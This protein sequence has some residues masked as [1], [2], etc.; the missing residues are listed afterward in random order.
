MNSLLIT[1][2][3]LMAVKF[4]FDIG[5]AGLFI[6]LLRYFSKE[7]DSKSIQK[8]LNAQSKKRLKKESMITSIFAIFYIIRVL[9]MDLGYQII[10]LIHF[11]DQDSNNPILDNIADFEK[12]FIRFSL[13]TV[14]FLICMVLLTLFK[15]YAIKS[16]ANEEKLKGYYMMNKQQISDQIAKS[17]NTH[18]T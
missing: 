18:S 7:R 14:D 1:F 12:K 3:I 9:I 16:M 17:M 5:M 4:L 2:R 15:M 13:Y 8:K 6:W 10:L 11:I